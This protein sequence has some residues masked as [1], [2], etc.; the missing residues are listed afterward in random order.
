M[1]VRNQ[2][3][4]TFT[5]RLQFPQ[6]LRVTTAALMMVC[7]KSLPLALALHLIELKLF[8][9]EC[10]PLQ[11]FGFGVFWI[12]SLKVQREFVFRSGA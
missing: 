7:V 11:H 8:I 4:T 3:V 12:C 10:P 9:A 5:N 2:L 6:E 1:S